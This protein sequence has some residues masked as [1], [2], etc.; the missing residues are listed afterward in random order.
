MA[1]RTINLDMSACDNR[2]MRIGSITSWDGSASE[3]VEASD[4]EQ[5]SKGEK[6]KGCAGGKGK[7]CQLCELHMPF[8][9]Q[10]MCANAIVGCQIGNITD[11]ILIDHGPIGC[12]ANHARFNLGY[13]MGLIRRG[14]PVE[15]LRIFSTNLK[16]KDMVFGASDRLRQ[17][18]QDAFDRYHP[19]AIFI[20]MSCSTAI[21]GE[22]ID[23]VADEME[24]ELGIPIVPLHCEG[25]RSN[26]IPLNYYRQID[27][28]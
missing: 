3:L 27:E 5:R 15:N 8:S 21:I 17:T 1:K 4:Y 24:Y 11:C 22:D 20:S 13:K 19:K 10:T 9:Q 18:I 16:E 25:F 6:R 2:E 23:S 7:M 28:K 14:K 12:S 26:T